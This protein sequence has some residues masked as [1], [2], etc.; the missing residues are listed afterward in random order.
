MSLERFGP[1]YLNNNL[2][3]L[4]SPSDNQWRLYRMDRGAIVVPSE[5]PV[6][7]EDG[8]AAIAY[9]LMLDAQGL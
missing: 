2:A 8:Y 9:A 5:W 7:F 4:L 1:G 3:V 6:S